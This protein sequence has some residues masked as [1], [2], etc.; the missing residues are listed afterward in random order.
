VLEEMVGGGHLQRWFSSLLL[1]H[2]GGVAEGAVTLALVHLLAAD[3]RLGVAAAVASRVRPAGGCCYCC[4]LGCCCCCIRLWGM[5]CAAANE[6]KHS[7]AVLLCY[8]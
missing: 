4:C 8:S 2:A 3:G 5:V 7:T 6:V 1:L